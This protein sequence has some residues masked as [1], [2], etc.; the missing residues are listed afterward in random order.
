MV[1]G[2]IS[3]FFCIFGKPFQTNLKMKQ[4]IEI[5]NDIH[6]IEFSDKNTSRM[7][8][9]MWDHNSMC[10][11]LSLSVRGFR[12]LL[13]LI[14]S[15]QN[16]NI[17]STEKDTNITYSLTKNYLYEALNLTDDPNRYFKLI[18]A[19]NELES[20]IT[21]R[22]K[23]KDGGVVNDTI[24]I[25]ARRIIAEFDNTVILTVTSYFANLVSQL[26][27]YTCLIP[28]HFLS[29]SSAIHL[30]LYIF[31]KTSL[32]KKKIKITISDLMALLDISY[33]T[34]VLF[35]NTLGIKAPVG[36][37]KKTWDLTTDNN[38]NVTGA[39]GVICE[40][41]DI[42]VTAL[43]IKTGKAYTHIEF[44]IKENKD[45]TSRSRKASLEAKEKAVKEKAR[46][47]QQKRR[48]AEKVE[49]SKVD[50]QQPIA[51]KEEDP[52]AKMM[53]ITNRLID[54]FKC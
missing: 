50:T 54:K 8:N 17:S 37:T 33:P 26:N 27:F 25:L 52:K 4:T 2:V 30:W 47:N 40:K 29:L 38:G 49:Q 5:K 18:Q 14:H 35:K 44:T 15:A 28:E 41:T 45:R 48:L 31:L 36:S 42:L 9:E 10:I 12:L 16:L 43:P 51:F 6:A 1:G 7:P 24:Y 3:P 22:T 11:S 39:I 23:C 13:S 46:I 21:L 32:Q 19:L 34:S 20:G 53:D